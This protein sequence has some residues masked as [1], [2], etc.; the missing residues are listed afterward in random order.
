MFNIQ[1]QEERDFNLGR[2]NSLQQAFADSQQQWNA[3]DDRAADHKALADLRAAGRFVLINS[4][5]VFCPHTDAIMGSH[6][7]IASDHA[8]LEEARAAMSAREWDGEDQPEIKEPTTPEYLAAKQAA[9]RTQDGPAID[10][11]DIP[12]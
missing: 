12:F 10:D 2:Q 7:Q 11:K 5:P 4:Y 3:N 8:T 6:F 9:Q 1:E